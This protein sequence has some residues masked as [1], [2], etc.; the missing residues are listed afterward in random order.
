MIKPNPFTPKSGQEPRIF[1][2]REGEISF[3]EKRLKELKINDTNHYILNGSWGIGK[4]SLLKY[5][6]L[7]AQEKSFH[8][9]YFSIEEFHEDVD[10]TAITVHLLQSISRALSLRFKKGSPFLKLLQGFGIQVLGTGFNINF[11]VD[12]NILFDSPTLLLDGLLNIWKELKKPNG[13]VVLIDDVQNLSRVTRYMTTIR[14]VLSHDDIIKKT[15]FLF[16]LS[17]TLDGWKPFMIRNHPI[18]RFFI[19]R[20]ELKGFNQGNTYKLIEQTLENTGV[21]FD[22]KI[23]PFVWEYTEGHLFELHS[24]CRELYDLQEKGFVSHGKANLALENCMIY[25]GTAIFENLLSEI[26][27]KE[28]EILYAISFFKT[29]QDTQEIERKTQKFNFKIKGIRQYLRRLTDKNM[30][31]NPRRGMYFIKDAMLRLY[32]NRSHA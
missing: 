4:T 5:F 7:F 23:L 11:H 12:K 18:G 19:P 8:A 28:K 32:I 20:V 27:E 16:I 29:P 26:S 30:I 9:A 2:N 17:S 24:L 15:K 10:S 1:L 6:K 25:L 3:F 22:Q 13:V 31:E 14:N 21:K